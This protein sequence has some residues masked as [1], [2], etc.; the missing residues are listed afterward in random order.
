MKDIRYL[1]AEEKKRNVSTNSDRKKMFQLLFEVYLQYLN[2]YKALD[3]TYDQMVHPQKRIV[4][5]KLLDIVIGRLNEL[6]FEFVRCDLSENT[7]FDEVA[8]FEGVQP[9]DLDIPIPKYY[10]HD[11]TPG[12]IE[13][14]Q[15]YTNIKDRK[16]ILKQKKE[17]EEQKKR[18]KQMEEAQEKGWD[19]TELEEEKIDFEDTVL[20][21]Q[22]MER[23]RQGKGRFIIAKFYQEEE[24][25]FQKK[26]QKAKK[27]K[28][29]QEKATI[30]IQK[31]VRG[32][33]ARRRVKKLRNEELE[34]LGIRPTDTNY[35]TD[36]S[37]DFFYRFKNDKCKD[38]ATELERLQESRRELR[39]LMQKQYEEDQ[40]TIYER[41]HKIEGPD[42]AERF[43][44]QI[45]SWYMNVKEED[46]KLPAIPKAD[47][48]GSRMMICPETLPEE[49]QEKGRMA[50]DPEYAAKKKAEKKRLRD[51]KKKEKAKLKALKAKG[52]KV[53]GKKSEIVENPSLGPPQFM[54]DFM[55]ANKE[56]NKFWRGL[57]DKD[58]PDQKHEM[59]YL[60]REKR[61]VVADE[62]RVKVDIEMRAELEYLKV[63]LKEKKGKKKGKKGKKGK[64]KKK[65]KK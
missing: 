17:E 59:K 48:G 44:Y 65:K 12:M 7:Y 11:P 5:R 6:R 3:E 18:G 55:A 31:L 30:I 10:F 62:V 41:L 36:F 13:R 49:V 47:V 33:L 50:T 64:G 29:D 1:L 43:K 14:D 39:R 57:D 2:I 52:K 40:V 22:S 51:Q 25:G 45:R 32:F 28:M 35:S 37:Y 56:Y 42:M 60:I 54:D 23:A 61:Q 27:H 53:K 19:P 15:W 24:L 46:G 16:K 26:K 9:K 4:V 38:N 21:V 34:F 20:P 58:N 63:A 8:L